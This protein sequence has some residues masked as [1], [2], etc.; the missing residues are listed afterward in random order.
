MLAH[1][2]DLNAKQLIE[3]AETFGIEISEKNAD[4]I[5]DDPSIT[6]FVYDSISYGQDDFIQFVRQLIISINPKSILIIPHPSTLQLLINI[7][8]LSCESHLLESTYFNKSG[9]DL[10]SSISHGEVQFCTVGKDELDSK[11]FDIV[12]DL[13]P[14]GMRGSIEFESL[15][16]RAPLKETGRLL[17]LAAP[18]FFLTNKNSGKNLALRKGYNLSANFE[19]P[20]GFFDRTSIVASLVILNKGNQGDIFA[21]RA[22]TEKEGTK[23]V[24]SNWLGNITSENPEFGVNVNF[25]EFNG[26]R[27]IIARR[28]LKVLAENRGYTQI[29]FAD[30]V[31][32]HKVTRSQNFERLKHLPNSVY[33]PKMYAKTTLSQ[34]KLSERLK[35]YI[36]LEMNKDVV[37]ARFFSLLMND[38]F[39]KQMYEC[40][41]TGNTMRAISQSGLKQLPIY[42][43]T[44]ERQQEITKVY[45]TIRNVESELETI[46]SKCWL[47]EESVDDFKET[48]SKFAPKNSVDYLQTEL[49]FPLASILQL[50]KSFTVDSHKEKY[51]TL[52]HFFEASSLFSAVIHLSAWNNNEQFDEHWT[53]VNTHMINID[54]QWITKPTFGSWNTINSNFSKIYRGQWSN[55]ET[56]D[57][58]V[59]IFSNLDEDFLTALSSKQYNNILNGA[60]TIRNQ[61]KGHSGVVGSEEA[62]TH[63][64][65]LLDLLDDYRSLFSNCLTNVT[66]F[67]PGKGEMTTD[68][69]SCDMALLKGAITPFNSSSA[70][71]NY[72]PHKNRLYLYSS[73]KKNFIELLQFIKLG[74]TPNDVLN[75]CYFFG[76]VKKD[77]HKFL[78]YHSQAVTDVYENDP[79]V[80][81][82]INLLT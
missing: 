33:I 54:K 18:N 50:Y 78:N 65:S 60:N 10:L 69:Y 57:S 80:Q 6:N 46:R 47:S 19:F 56:R 4:L 21:A 70:I 72:P 48:I 55:S 2:R 44:L 32:S 20:A 9:F 29:N 62:K 41:A 66:L 22:I 5:L 11:S 76:G 73:P 23:T 59:E 30:A 34:D 31:I 40:V 38:T 43:P 13:C 39:G 17:H 27:S 64:R 77:G 52:L 68:G 45:E 75:S 26:L 37:D 36:Q 3:I 16:E 67:A 1:Q 24:I 28:E 82:A 12:I 58:L 74:A 8:D 7:K 71:F 25:N 63:H 51:E 79:L 49:P 15:L 53:R 35:S 61:H 42:L 14:L 81:N